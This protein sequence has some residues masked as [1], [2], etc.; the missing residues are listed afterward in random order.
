MRERRPRV[1]GPYRRRNGYRVYV[2]FPDGARESHLLPTEAA[3][4]EFIVAFRR[5]VE[6]RT[7]D[8]AIDAY[9]ADCRARGLKATTV[10]TYEFRLRGLLGPARHELLGALTPAR[11]A[12]LY[13][14][15]ATKRKVDTHRNELVTAQTWGA[16]VVKRG[17]LAVGPFAEVEPTGA[18]R[19]GKPRLRVDEAK[20]FVDV[21]LAERTLDGLAAAMALLMGLRASE[22]TDRIVR[23]VDA[24]ATVLWIDEAKTTASERRVSVPP[25]LRPRLAELVTGR[26]AAERLFGGRDRH[27]LAYHVERI[28]ALAKVPRVTPHGLRGTAATIAVAAADISVVAAALGHA[29][30]QV[31]RDH[32]LEPGAEQ[33]AQQERRLVA[34]AGGKS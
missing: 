18:R 33:A 7:V 29:D 23:D 9:V 30:A 21:A 27:W 31:T 3:A 13:R 2:S 26:D 11:A 15:R 14:D 4:I 19:R 22:V 16:W 6:T 34:L 10:T 25:V 1:N 20:A 24:G 5:H 17:W 32:Y 12:R 28:A 8:D